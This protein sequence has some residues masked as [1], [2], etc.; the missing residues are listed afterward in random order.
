MPDNMGYAV[1]HLNGLLRTF[2]RKPHVEKD[3]IEFMGK[4]LDTAHAV[5]VPDEGIPSRQVSGKLW[6]LP[7]FEVYHPKSQTKFGKSS[8]PLLSVKES[9]SAKNY[10]Q[11]HRIRFPREDVVQEQRPFRADH[12]VS[13]D[14]TSVWE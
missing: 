10:S 7:Q 11:V 8:T 4:M 3:Y 2:K 12:R 6:Y 14:S 1:K 5:P 9:L 13:N